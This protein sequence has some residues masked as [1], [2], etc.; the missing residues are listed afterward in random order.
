LADR[1]VIDNEPAIS[2][3]KRHF[4][5]EGSYIPYGADLDR[6]LTTDYIEE[7]GLKPRGYLL[8]VG[9][10]VPDKGPD[11]LID[12]FRQVKADIP[13][14]IV[15]DSPFFPEYRARL[16]AS[17]DARIRF[18]GYVYGQRYR[19]L[20]ANAYA[21][22]HP[23]RSDGTSPAL[24]QA[25]AYGNCIVVNGLPEAVSAVR[26]TALAYRRNDPADLARL[27]EQI[28]ANPEQANDLRQQARARAESHYDWD[29][30]TDQHEELYTSV[31]R[32]APLAIGRPTIG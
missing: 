18:V 4:G 19:E 6:P 24:L 26:D 15:G 30:V 23:L 10:L 14:I 11:I 1:L 7:L 31:V 28:I 12:A 2:Y 8:F 9:A 25:M 16:K 13:L 27:L 5:Y 32:N 17:P 22:V 20:L 3:F 21:Y 29:V